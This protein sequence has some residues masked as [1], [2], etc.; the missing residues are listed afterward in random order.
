MFKDAKVTT[1]ERDY[2]RRHVQGCQSNNPK[3]IIADVMFKDAK[4]TTLKEIIADVM[5]KDAKDNDPKETTR[6][7]I[8]KGIHDDHKKKILDWD[9]QNFHSTF[10]LFWL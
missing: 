1:L 9:L 10:S 3:R 8:E 5:V 2:C 6:D 4:V 7:D